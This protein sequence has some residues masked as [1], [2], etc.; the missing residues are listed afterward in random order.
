MADAFHCVSR[1]RLEARSASATAKKG[2]AP[3]R[4]AA[5]CLDSNGRGASALRREGLL[6]RDTMLSAT[7]S[8]GGRRAACPAAAEVVYVHPNVHPTL[9]K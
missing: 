9:L 4:A 7:D 8:I 2:K 5:S 6:L 3:L 1:R